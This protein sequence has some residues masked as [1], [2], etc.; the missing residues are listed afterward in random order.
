[1]PNAGMFDL[2][3][4]SE[5]KEAGEEDDPTGCNHVHPTPLTP[6]LGKLT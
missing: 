4:G 3:H 6:T 2:K 5:W 1:M